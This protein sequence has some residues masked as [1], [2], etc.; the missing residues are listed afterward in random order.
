[1]DRYQHG[2]GVAENHP[3][4]GSRHRLDRDIR[5]RAIGPGPGHLAGQP[6][7][8]ITPRT[9]GGS[10]CAPAIGRLTSTGHQPAHSCRNEG[11]AYAHVYAKTCITFH[12]QPARLRRSGNCCATFSCRRIEPDRRIG[13]CHCLARCGRRGAQITHSVPVSSQ[14]Q[15]TAQLSMRVIRNSPVRAFADLHL[16]VSK[17]LISARRA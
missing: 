8:T 1:V 2:H 12:V 11:V 14:N 13:I 10:P 6:A 3:P 16:I 9:G 7:V 15:I 5:N 4:A 17:V